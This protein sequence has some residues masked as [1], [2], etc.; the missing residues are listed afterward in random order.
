MVSLFTVLP[1]NKKTQVMCLVVCL[2]HFSPSGVL[3][4]FDPFEVF[5][6]VHLKHKVN[7]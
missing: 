6:T 2:E 5:V 7:K 3:T 1:A 4:T